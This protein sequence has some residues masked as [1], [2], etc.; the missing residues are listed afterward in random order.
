M[1]TAQVHTGLAVAATVLGA[2]PFHF[3]TVLDRWG[4]E[5]FQFLSPQQIVALA[6]VKLQTEDRLWLGHVT[7][8]RA[9]G[10]EWRTTMQVEHSLCGLPELLNLASRFA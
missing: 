10:E 2:R 1:V 4:A 5:P 8:C 7:E 9:E 3:H 6:P